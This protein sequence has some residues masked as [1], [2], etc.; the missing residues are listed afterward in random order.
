MRRLAVISD[1]SELIA[2][3]RARA[4][5][6]NI[7]NLTIDL[8]SGMQSGYTSKCLAIRPRRTLGRLSLGLVLSTLGLKL[9]VLEDKEQLARMRPRLERRKKNGIHRRPAGQQQR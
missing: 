6:L 2:A 8:V 1:Y 3:L 5:A 4:D 7:S 9:A